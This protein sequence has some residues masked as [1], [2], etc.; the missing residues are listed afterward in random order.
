MGDLTLNKESAAVRQTEAAIDAFERG[1][2][3]ICITLAG[4]AEGIFSD[5]KG[6]DFHTFALNS[7]AT[8][9]FNKKQTNAALNTERDWLK[10]TTLGQP[11]EITITPFEAA[12]MIMRA[13]T[14][15][16]NWSEKMNRIK[17]KLNAILLSESADN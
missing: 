5:R 6:S 1:D 9:Q 4:A 8:S 13:M 12:Y 7:A 16:S 14:K 15:L 17:P 10:H 3:D 2:Y 11:A